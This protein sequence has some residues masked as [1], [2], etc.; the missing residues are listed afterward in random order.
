MRI[1]I[2]SVSLPY[3]PASGGEIRAHGIIEGLRKAGHDLSLLC[4]HTGEINATQT[5]DLRVIT[6]PPPTRTIR[7]RLRNLILTRQPDIARRF[8]SDTMAERLR[9]L[10]AAE[11]FDLIQFEGIEAVCYL[12]IAKDSQPA[13][14]LVFDTFN[15]EYSLQRGI[16][17]ID[18]Q[19]IRRW[20]AALYSL[21]QSRRIGN[22]ERQMCHRADAVIAVSPEDADLLRPFR[23]DE[24]IHIVP[25]GIWVDNY[26]ADHTT[27]DLGQNA[28]VFTGKMDYRP[29]VDA[30]LWF[31]GEIYP[32]V[33]AQIPD[34]HLY[35]VGQ[36]PH[37]RLAPLRRMD[38]VQ[39]TGRVDSVLPYLRAAAVYVAPLRMGSGTRL[40]LLE[41]MASGCAI[42]ATHT[43]SAGL[44]SD[45][46]QTMILADDNA[47]FADAV[48]QLLQNPVRRR[49]LGEAARAQVS[50]HYDWPVLIPR[51][52][53]VY[54]EIGASS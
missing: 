2:V 14:K 26:T 44:L 24:R 8:Y 9:A 45:A 40:K 16:Y 28:L 12:P 20:P 39:L 7:D 43:A 3:P 31:T 19:N 21:I 47:D 53:D 29:N 22:F 4:F 6:V 34:A 49:E 13:A 36:Q 32:H 10:L 17:Y 30:A 52:L 18:R 46:K 41:A 50:R 5:G 51:L 54:R 48:I 38:D 33:R 25:S 27:L 1:L 37:P 42:V 11:S 35:I 15:A 23:P